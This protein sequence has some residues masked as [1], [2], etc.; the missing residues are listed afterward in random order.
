MFSGLSLKTRSWS[1]HFPGKLKIWQRRRP[2]KSWLRL[3][4]SEPKQSLVFWEPGSL[5]FSTLMINSQN[6]INVSKPK[7]SIE[8]YKAPALEKG[9]DIL[10]FLA[11]FPEGLC[12][13]D[14]AKGLGRSLNEIFRMVSVL[15]KRGYILCDPETERFSLSLKLFSIANRYQPARMMVTKAHPKMM[16][17]TQ[18]TDQSCHL[19]IFHNGKILIIAQVEA[20]RW[21]L[22]I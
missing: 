22:R 17:L 3:D 18:A 5:P 16:Q 1:K 10:E 12:K 15:E 2:Q 19:G 13:V 8:K 20:P 21:R 7:N 6:F 14:I 11:D 4:N 9:L